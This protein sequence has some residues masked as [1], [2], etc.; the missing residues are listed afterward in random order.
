MRNLWKNT[1]HIASTW[2]SSFVCCVNTMMGHIDC[3]SFRVREKK[4][5]PLS[6]VKLHNKENKHIMCSLANARQLLFILDLTHTGSSER[7]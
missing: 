4:Y 1:A 3:G 6:T 2:I 7:K 5:E